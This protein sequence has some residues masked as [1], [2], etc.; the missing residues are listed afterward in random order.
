MSLLRRPFTLALLI[1]LVLQINACSRSKRSPQQEPTPSTPS[2]SSTDSVTRD[3]VLVDSVTAAEKQ[4]LTFVRV[5]VRDSRRLTALVDSLGEAQWTQTLKLNRVDR[6]HVRDG[7]TLVLAQAFRDSLDLA[8]FPRLLPSVQD[9]AKL[10][11]VSLRL[12]AFA[13][14]DSGRLV[15]WGPTSTGR[16]NKPTPAGS[17]HVNWKDRERISTVDDEWQLFWCVNIQNREGVS[18]HQYE[19]PGRP[20]SHSCVRLLERDAM[21][22]YAWTDQW[23]LSPNG[24]LAATGTPVVVFG[25]WAWGERAPW[26]RLPEDPTAGL[27][28]PEEIDEALRTLREG[29]QR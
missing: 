17:Y 16:R 13:A 18:L 12:Q 21:W 22:V 3:T 25:A 11:L 28:G 26:K 10:V 2:P 29:V 19:L 14:Y 5:R 27:L 7:D 6:A 23:K 9:T 20:A 24:R 8:P 15:Q 1:S 4:P